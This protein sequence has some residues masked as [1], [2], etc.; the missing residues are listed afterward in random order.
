MS[1]VVAMLDSSAAARPVL[2]TAIRVG[3][4]TGS[5]VEALHVSRSDGSHSA[6]ETLASRYP[7]SFRVCP[8]PVL[9]S[10]LEALSAPEVVAAVV[11]ARSVPSGRRPLGGT[12]QQIVESADKP[13]VIVPPEVISPQAF[14]SLLVPLEGTD[15][16]SRAVIEQ[17]GPLIAD[18]VEVVVLHVFTDATLP[19]MLD[20]PEYDLDIL[21][22][23]FLHAQFPHTS[24]IELRLGPVARRI[25]E[26]SAEQG[27]DLIVL[28][29]LQDNSPHRAAVI[30]EILAASAI[31]VLLLPP[32]NP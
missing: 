5:E 25:R 12:A 26:V 3:Q 7:V 2:E 18:E 21:G 27:T 28:S 13:L 17:L 20:R 24:R 1:V 10:L 14:R 22:K 29:W 30:R 11:G 16:T 8:S 6:V 4:L 23:E 31:P 32:T 19:P 9:P 15:D